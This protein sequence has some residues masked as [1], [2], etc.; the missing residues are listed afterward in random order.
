MRTGMNLAERAG[1]SLMRRK[2]HDAAFDAG[3]EFEIGRVVCHGWFPRA[4]C[5]RVPL[6]P[7]AGGRKQQVSREQYAAAPA[8]PARQTNWIN[9]LTSWRYWLYPE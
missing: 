6:E 2:A 4:W 5:N 8:K 3:L 1:P 7:I 9:N